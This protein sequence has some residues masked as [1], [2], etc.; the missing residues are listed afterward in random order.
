MKWLWCLS[1][2]L[3]IFNWSLAP[4]LGTETDIWWHL[5]AGQRFWQHGLELTDPYSFTEAG[6][7]WVRIDWLFQV[8]VYPIYQRGGLP[9]LILLRSACLLGGAGLVAFMLRRRSAAERW[10]LALLV[11]SIWSYAIALRPATVSFFFTTLWV[12]VLELGRGGRRRALW[13]LPPLMCLW[14]NLHVASLAGILLLGL[15]AV[16]HTLEKARDRQPPDRVWWQV[17]VASFLATMLN[18]Q[19]WKT[20]FYPIHFMFV[21]SP[22]RALI[23]EVQPPNWDT[24]GAW[25]ARLLLGLSLVGA[26]QALRRREV[27]PLLVTLVTGYLMNSAARHQYQLCAAL[28]P[29]AALSL[30]SLLQRSTGLV[31]GLLA[32]QALASTLVLR[33]PLGGLVRRESFSQRLAALT[34]QGAP[35]LRVFVDMN[36]AGYFLYHFDGRQ[37]VFIDSRTDQVYMQPTILLDHQEIWTG[38]ERALQLLDQY[39]IQAVVNNRLASEGSPLWEKLKQSG[40]WTC[41]SSDMVGELYVRND[42]ASQFREPPPPPFQRDFLAAFPLEA[43]GS[44]YEAEASWQSSLN[45]YPQFASA[46]QW[47]A[48]LWTAQGKRAQAKRALAR[49]EAYHAETT[50]LNEDWQKIGI[51]W[52]RWLRAYAL[53][54]WAL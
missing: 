45:D 12:T 35:G 1:A 31:A 6:H 40:D 48:K 11:A 14:F 18:P 28:V 29:W 26:A 41:V 15:Y 7:V 22:W 49:A 51:T 27:T 2:A 16:G 3:I 36:G 19:G 21:N 44:I 34:A 46:H 37:K 47:L 33:L 13:A 23:L 25:Q 39:Q 42:L 50:G 10:L 5:A 20:V 24:P 53:P 43:A 9:A 52:P 54:F 17:L 30:P 4:I 8:L 32:A 38:G